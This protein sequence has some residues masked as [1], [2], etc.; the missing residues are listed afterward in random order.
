MNRGRRERMS[1]GF[2]THGLPKR[3]SQRPAL[4]L[5]AAGFAFAMILTLVSQGATWWLPS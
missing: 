5:I 4:A 1:R 2:A 3:K